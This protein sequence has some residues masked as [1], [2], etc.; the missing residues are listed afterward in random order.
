[1]LT[2]LAATLR[3]QVS[4]TRTKHTQ[5]RTCKMHSTMQDAFRE[6]SHHRTDNQVRYQSTNIKRQQ[7]TSCSPVMGTQH[8]DDVK[9]SFDL[10]RAVGCTWDLVVDNSVAAEEVK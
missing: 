7:E 2:V 1:M 4:D 9:S 6:K 3:N 5:A 8:V 10:S